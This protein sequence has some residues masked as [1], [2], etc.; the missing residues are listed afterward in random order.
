LYADAMWAAIHE[1]QWRT[2]NVAVARGAISAHNDC[3]STVSEISSAYIDDVAVLDPILAARTF[4]IGRNG[5]AMTD[6][7][8]DGVAARRELSGRTLTSLEQSSSH[9]D[10]ER[11]G[12]LFLTEFLRGDIGLVDT[13]ERES[14]VSISIGPPAGLR[15][16]FDLTGPADSDDAAAV[17]ERLAQVPAA[18]TGYQATLQQGRDRGYLASQRATEAVIAQLETWGGTGTD[19][20]YATF[21]RSIPHA[22]RARADLAGGLADASYR[23]LAAWLRSEYLQHALPTDGVGTDRH[24]VW[25][26]AMLGCDLDLDDVYA[27]GWEELAGLQRQQEETAKDVVPGGSYAEVCHLLETDPA[28][29]IGGIDPWRQW[30]QEVTDD[31]I[32]RL[33]GVHF[34]IPPALRTCV[35]SIPPEGG[36]AAPYY[37]A[38]TED[39]SQPG[40]IWF[41]TVGA[42]RFATWDAVS[43]VYHEA[44]PGHHLERGGTRVLPLTRAQRLLGNSGHLEGWALYAE[45]LM[46]ELGFLGDP[47]FRLG[48]L[49]AQAFRAARIVIDVGLHTRRTIPSG[50]PHAGETWTYEIAVEYLETASGRTRPFCESEILRYLSWPSQATCYKLGE[51]TWLAGRA[52]SEQRA[53]AEF[54]LKRWHRDALALGPLGLDDLRDELAR[55]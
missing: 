6:Y 47:K 34:D 24:R 16:S 42:T 23:E 11:R 15:Q 39:L 12:R 25:A 46:D 9:D 5:H 21:A 8:P 32:E 18:M 53:G 20:W 4:G 2:Q 13:G 30:L 49:S 33:D 52:A 44:V 35:V 14:T 40:R 36:A 55:L 28:Y 41:P 27:W 31:A 37:T 38:P 22:D 10:T 1:D 51:R 7:S 54:D 29:S 48:F 43:T 3:V 45:R 50:W 19:G 26:R 17:V